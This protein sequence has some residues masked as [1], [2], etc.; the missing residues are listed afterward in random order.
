MAAGHLRA[1]T[2]I[3]RWDTNDVRVVSYNAYW[4]SPFA[5]SEDT[6]PTTPERFRRMMT[7]L[8][9][10]VLAVQEMNAGSAVAMGLLLEQIMPLANGGRWSVH[11]R[12]DNVIA[13]RYPILSRS[14]SLG[15]ADVLVDLPNDRFDSDLYVISDHWPCCSYETE[16]QLEADAMVNWIDRLKGPTSSLPDNTPLIVV[17]DLNIVGTQHPLNTLLTGNAVNSQIADSAPDWDGTPLTSAAPLHNGVG[18]ESYTWRDDSDIYDPGVLDYVVYTDSVLETANRFL[19]NTRSM[20]ESDLA[21]TD[22]QADDVMTKASTGFYDHLPLVVDFRERPVVITGDYDR[23]GMIDEA[24]Y[25]TWAEQYGGVN[26]PPAD[27]NGDGVVNTADYT[28]WRDAYDASLAAT[29]VPEPCSLLLAAGIA[30]AGASSPR[31]G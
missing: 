23:D 8:Q 31:R 4:N 25:A 12:S 6:D 26:A 16:R 21:L 27:G 1:A 10:D 11:Q 2:F 9:P 3:D 24:D 5:P 20:S 29:A 17:G 19:L 7:A 18:P 15:H 13:S 14:G 22:L 30:I 28:V